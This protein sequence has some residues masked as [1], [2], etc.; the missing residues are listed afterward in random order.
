MPQNT[1]D[2][3]IADDDAGDRKQILRALKQGGLP[4]TCTETVS[5]E[6]A[7]QA[8]ERRAFDCA[9]VD[10]RL[11]GEDGLTGITILHQRLPD[12]AIIMVTGQGDEM[13]ATEAMKRGASDYM[14]KK[15]VE[16][17][18]IRRTIRSEER[19]VGK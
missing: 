17:Q 13:V 14:P 8:C 11:T 15:H 16:A 18:S 7:L 1:I 19:R 4:C 9:L 3:L 10:Y 6:D 2:I 5:I 12:M